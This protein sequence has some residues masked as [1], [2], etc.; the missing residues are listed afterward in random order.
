[1]LLMFTEYI[2]RYNN[3]MRTYLVLLLFSMFALPFVRDT[4]QIDSAR[5]EDSLTKRKTDLT[6]V[7]ID[8]IR[9]GNIDLLDKSLLVTS[10]LQDF[11]TLHPIVVHFAISLI[12]IAAILQLVNLFVFKKDIAWIVFF[13]ILTGFIVALLA[14]KNFHPHTTNLG[15]R[16][17]IVLEL[18]DQWAGWT[19]R[20]ALAGMILQL[21][22]ILITRRRVVR[23]E[24]GTPKVYF[25]KNTG[26]M[27]LVTVTL[28]TSAYSVI[29]AG[30]Y[31]AQLVHIEGVGPQ[32]KYLEPEDE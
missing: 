12:V 2:S 14:S 17:A 4:Q 30:L 13:M 15:I 25:K 19:I 5:I 24:D 26:L 29:R 11:P 16:S 9:K 7:K 8:T 3:Q 1:M 21:V 27:I 31:G 6:N 28:L 23:T 18:H 20:T 10:R 32:G 22:Y